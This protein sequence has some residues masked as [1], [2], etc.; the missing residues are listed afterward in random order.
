MGGVELGVRV[1]WPQPMQAIKAPA[2]LRGEFTIP[3]DHPVR[4]EEYSVT[5]HVNQA[6][7][8]D[9]EW[10]PKTGKKVIV[11]GDSFVQAAQVGLEEGFGRVLDGLLEGAEVESMG[12]PGAGTATAL[13]VLDRYALPRE[14]D[15]VILGFLV[16]NDVLNNH[17]LLE[18]KDDKPFYTLQNGQLIPTDAANILLPP[19]WLYQHS[20]A[21]RWAARAWAR[22]EAVAQKLAL[23][24]GMPIDLRV[25]DP[26]GGPIW[27]EAWGVTGALIRRM[28]DHCAAFNVK[29]GV[30]LFPDGL[31]ATEGGRQRTLQAWPEAATWDL[32]R[33]QA[34]AAEVAGASAQVFDLLPALQN[35]ENAYFPK[36]GHWTPEGHRLAAEGSRH[37]IQQLLP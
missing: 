34:H 13:G 22:R 9:R 27:D 33:A 14:P 30:L 19:G 8:V 10:G 16:A 21:F 4:T 12:V 1:G 5:V 6:G 25:H 37:F 18:G 7:F 26:Q 31:Q 29:F 32:S 36:D 20:E 17:P 3:G 2:L 35:H 24:K 15:V 28:A 23:G 11:I